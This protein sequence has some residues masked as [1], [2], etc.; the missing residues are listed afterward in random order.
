MP[1]SDLVARARRQQTPADLDRF[2]DAEC[3]SN[4]ELRAAVLRELE[5]VGTD[6]PISAGTQL[7]ETFSRDP[8]STPDG[9]DSEI[10][11]AVGDT[12]AGRYKVRERL[13]T[14]G[15]GTIFVADQIAPVERRVALKVIKA[16]MDS[17]SVLARFAQERQT[18]ALMDHPNIAR[19]YDGGMTRLGRPYF[20]MELVRGLPLT[21][22]C[23]TQKLS[24]RQ[25][26]EL[27]IPI[28]RAV[29]HAHQ[30]GIIHRDLK[31]RNI[32]VGL[33]DGTPAP[34]VIDFGVAK[35]LNHEL[36]G[37]SVYTKQEA[38][39]GTVEY[40]APEQ[41]SVDA[42][43]IDTRADIYSLGVVLY[44]LLCGCVP[45]SRR[46]ELRGSRAEAARAIRDIEPKRPSAKLTE[47]EDT[48]AVA[49]RR[50]SDPSRLRQSLRG[51]LDWV[52]MKCLEK[53]RD[54]R[55]ATA[56][57]L[58]GD[59]ERFLRDEPVLAA[60]P[61]AR[62]RLSK[63]YRRHSRQVIAAGLVLL[64]LVAAVVATTTGWLRAMR[65][66][67]QARDEAAIHRA[68]AR[69]IQNDMLD[70]VDASE[71]MKLGLPPDAHVELRTL[72]DRVSRQVR[73]GK[74]ADQ[75]PV[76]AAMRLTLAKA[77]LSLGAHDEALEHAARADQIRV[78]V[79]GPEAPDR[80]ETLEMIGKVHKSADRPQPAMEAFEQ[81]LDLRRRLNGA[82]DPRTLK[83]RYHLAI[84]ERRLGRSAA[85]EHLRDLRADQV[86]LLTATHEDTLL[87]RHAYA[88]TLARA[89]KFADAEH[90]LKNLC[91]SWQEQRGRNFPDTLFAL[92][93][94]A[95]L[96]R[97]TGR[98]QLAAESFRDLV[99]R[100][101]AVYAAD[102]PLLAVFKNNLA[103][104]LLKL[105]KFDD[106][107]KL[108][109]AVRPV[110]EKVDPKHRVTL[111][112]KS[113]LATTLAKLGE[114]EESNRLYE[115]LLPLF[116]A[117]F[118]DRAMDTWNLLFDMAKYQSMQGNHVRAAELLT[119]L[120]GYERL[121]KDIRPSVIA[122]TARELAKELIHLNE[123][124]R[125]E[126]VLKEVL[127]KMPA[128]S[129]ERPKLE[130]ALQEV[131]KAVV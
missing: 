112:S 82:D 48:A 33:A 11:V 61:S 19:I 37:E 64:L 101:E 29:Q 69:F 65:A 22:F 125:A 24:I 17:K 73:D 129:P 74:L 4:A 66:E 51:D 72:L 89:G 54:R 116:L 70:S 130:K 47:T 32:L 67:R 92:N 102:H 103:A 50:K 120:L 10:D 27:F 75:P 77:Y 38:M 28:C 108:L 114:F 42:L 2:L 85:D 110:L 80:L 126:A 31:P 44:E 25:R 90:E 119:R 76:E 87:T 113:N 39:I 41:A 96:Y 46:T 98:P 78:A 123:R 26:V 111:V 99:Q 83:A 84:L 79:L 81:L 43:D 5:Q 40:M 59:L 45:L 23:D 1:P 93:T 128:D 115:E 15:M 122:Q 3:G 107:L 109:R 8:S 121:A 21:E 63:F 18:L 36:G 12:I 34:K 30:K 97:T 91:D 60:P 127:E 16:G 7:H 53:E 56:Q 58:A 117:S 104:T 52:V 118:G 14:G 100:A 106:A 9:Q 62:Y 86:R 105:Q 55:Y 94:L 131:H 71:R 68:L 13:G 57:G 49:T 6:E 35:A 95:D 88:E 20:V 124:R